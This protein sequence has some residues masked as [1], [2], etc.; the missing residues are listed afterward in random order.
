M[1]SLIEL[2]HSVE[3][4]NK[5]GLINIDSWRWPDVDHL[6]TMGFDFS[7]DY[8]MTTSKEPKITIYKKKEKEE[9]GKENTHLKGKNK[10]DK[11]NVY[12]YVEEENKLKKRFKD[13]ND[14]I[15]YFDTYEQPEIDKN[16]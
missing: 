15:D 13:F 16:K 2:L 1:I 14:V 3:E 11:D 4:E 12:F 10:S 8:H 9:T 7:D 5:S 6:V